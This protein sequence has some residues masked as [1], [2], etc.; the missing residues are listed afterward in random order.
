[1]MSRDATWP[2]HIEN[3]HLASEWI[4]DH[5]RTTAETEKKQKLHEGVSVA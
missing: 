1:M 3:D 5:R 2:D 4:L